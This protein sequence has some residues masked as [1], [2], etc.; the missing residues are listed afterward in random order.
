MLFKN[1]IFRNQTAE[2][3]HETKFLKGSDSNA[4]ILY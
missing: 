4:L 1:K 3:F 2:I